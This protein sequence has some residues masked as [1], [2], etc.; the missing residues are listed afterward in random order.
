MNL[1]MP[2]G[3]PGADKSAVGA[4]NRPLQGC[5]PCSRCPGYFV[6][7]G[8]AINRD[9]CP[10]GRMPTALLRSSFFGNSPTLSNWSSYS[11]RALRQVCNFRSDQSQS[12]T[13]LR[14]VAHDQGTTQAN[15]KMRHPVERL[16]ITA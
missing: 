5:C 7:R 11:L 12:I 10:P 6:N 3:L 1:D 2:L 8:P 13:Q 9:T 16:R 14:W 4:M 15:Q